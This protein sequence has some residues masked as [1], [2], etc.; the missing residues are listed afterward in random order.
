MEAVCEMCCGTYASNDDGNLPSACRLDWHRTMKWRGRY[1][2]IHNA[3]NCYSPTED[4]LDNATTNGWGGAWGMQELF[5]GTAMLHL[6]PGNCEGGWGYNGE[7][8][9]ILGQLT[10]F[11]KTNVLTDAELIAS[12]IFRKFDNALLHQTNLISIAQTELN[13]VLGDGIPATS[14]AAGSNPIERGVTENYN[15]WGNGRPNGWPRS[16]NEWLHSD[17]SKVA[18]FYVYDFFYKLTR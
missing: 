2:G 12:P 5:K 15:Y 9:D 8:T 1:A 3:I 11:A 17:I 7:H 18:Y 4:V 16:E 10:E 6:I 14:F 13:K